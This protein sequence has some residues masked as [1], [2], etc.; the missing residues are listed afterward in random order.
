MWQCFITCQ[1]LCLPNLLIIFSS[2]FT[3]WC[4]L[5]WDIFYFLVLKIF[6]FNK[7]SQNIPRHNMSRQQVK[8]TT[9]KNLIYLS[10]AASSLK[11]NFVFNFLIAECINWSKVILEHELETFRFWDEND[12]ED[13]VWLEPFCH[14]C[15]KTR[16][17]GNLHLLLFREQSYHGYLYWRWSSPFLIAKWWNF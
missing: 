3:M 15:Y 17:P 9:C 7:I 11:I 1:T 16:Y 2:S 14:L 8:S 13:E 4:L 12:Y 10:K 6:M 5:K